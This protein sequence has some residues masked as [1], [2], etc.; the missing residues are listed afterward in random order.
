MKVFLVGATGFVGRTATAFLLGQ[1]HDVVAWVR[2]SNQAKDQ[3]GRDV[4][5]VSED[6]DLVKEMENA[7]VV[8]NLSGQQLS[9]VRWTKNRKK[10]FYESRV[11]INNQLVEAMK[12]ATT[13]SYTHLTLPTKA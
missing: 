7:D 11:G 8:V 3:L 5:L 1:G 10:R 13:V 9:G 4:T 6:V 12:N 2:D